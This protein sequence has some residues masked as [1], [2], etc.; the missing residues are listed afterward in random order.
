LGRFSRRSQRETHQLLGGS[1]L[2]NKSDKAKEEAL[3]AENARLQAQYQTTINN[4]TPSPYEQALEDEG[5]AWMKATNGETPLDITKLPGMQP[6]LDVYN[7]AAAKQQGQRIGTGLMPYG[8]AMASPALIANLNLQE[9]AHRKQCPA[10]QLSNAFALR[11]AEVRGSAL[12]LIGITENRQAAKVG[13]TANMANSA[14]Q[15]WAQYQIRPGFW[16]GLLN[17]AT[18]GMG[19]GALAAAA[20]HI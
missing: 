1:A 8:S 7:T 18:Q 3:R 14:A 12:P 11:N 17:N 19:Q 2:G 16:A 6:Y 4:W 15:R 5:M 9:E 20:S 10:A 13:T